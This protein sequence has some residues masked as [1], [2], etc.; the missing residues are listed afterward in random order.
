MTHN[1][2]WTPCTL[3]KLNDV[4]RWNEPLWAQPSKPRGKRDKI[5]EQQVT[6]ELITRTDFLEFKVIA[7]EK[8]SGGDIPIKVVV[9]E[10]IKR[11]KSTIEMG[12]CH[13]LDSKN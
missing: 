7:V 9:G 5:G 4:L 2:K 10:T 11:K 8:I 13:K 6:A 1:Q 3:P 12:E